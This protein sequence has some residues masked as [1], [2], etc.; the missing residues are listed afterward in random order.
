MKLK[1]APVMIT[2]RYFPDLKFVSVHNGCVS[3]SSRYRNLVS[4]NAND[5]SN[6]PK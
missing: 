3:R 6:A 5:K 1:S 2:K 4:I